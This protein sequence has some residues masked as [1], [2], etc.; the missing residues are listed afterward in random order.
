MESSQSGVSSILP[1]DIT[2]KASLSPCATHVQTGRASTIGKIGKGLLGGS[3]L[4][5]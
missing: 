2:Q 4:K 1:T 5:R 3:P